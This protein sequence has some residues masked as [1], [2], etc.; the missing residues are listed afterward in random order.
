MYKGNGATIRCFERRLQKVI[1]CWKADKMKRLW[2]HPVICVTTHMRDGD[3]LN[4]QT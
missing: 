3:S 2:F 4:R 1:E